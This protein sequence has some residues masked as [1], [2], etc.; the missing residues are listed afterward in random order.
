MTVLL[1]FDALAIQEGRLNHQCVGILSLEQDFVRAG[2][3]ADPDQF[4]AAHLGAQHVVGLDDTL[5]RQGNAFTADQ[6]LALTMR[7][8]LSV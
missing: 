7:L 4:G 8:A 5:A 1:G 3:I 6:P 2:G